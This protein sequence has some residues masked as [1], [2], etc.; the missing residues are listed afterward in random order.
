MKNKKIIID[1]VDVSGCN[2]YADYNHCMM[3]STECNRDNCYYKQ[4]QRLTA[5]Y[6]KVIEQ[7]KSLQTE[8]K[9]K[10]QECE[11]LKKEKELLVGKIANSVFDEFEELDHYRKVLE[12][13]QDEYFKG[14]D[15]STIAELAK[16][17]I[18]LTTENRNLETALEE[19]ER[20]CVYL[21]ER[22]IYAESVIPTYLKPV[23][24]QDG[25]EDK[26]LDIIRKAKWEGNNAG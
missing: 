22:P 12:P 17:S 23:K 3:R 6:D 1:G 20:I 10:E 16:K 8:L 9:Q 18:R 5:Q 13:F 11:E 14:L 24:I 25:F 2:Y 21:Q 15:T 26:I 4:L 19:I 7:N